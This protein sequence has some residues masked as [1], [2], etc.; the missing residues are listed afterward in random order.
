M[1]KKSR[2]ACQKSQSDNNA[3]DMKGVEK[4]KKNENKDD[5]TPRN[6]KWKAYGMSRKWFLFQ[7]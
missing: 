1:K 6:F 3:K 5:R 2:N 7:N 4:G